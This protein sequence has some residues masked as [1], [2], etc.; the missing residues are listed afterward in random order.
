MGIIGRYSSRV[1]GLAIRLT[2][3]PERAKLPTCP[4]FRG[5]RF[6]AALG[7]HD[8]DREHLTE[9][10]EGCLQ[11]LGL[12][13]V[14]RVEHAADDGLADAEAARQLAVRDPLLTHGGVE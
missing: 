8:R 3:E 9:L 1:V 13:G 5:E 12:G 14:V 7:G 11:L 6:C 4:T 2:I 10:G